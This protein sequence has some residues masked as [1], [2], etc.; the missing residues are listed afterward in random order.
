MTMRELIH[1]L[2]VPLLDD[3]GNAYFRERVWGEEQ[4]GG[5]WHG[6]IEFV[7]PD[8]DS[9]LSTE[10]ETTQGRREALAYWATGLEPEYLEGALQRARYLALT[11]G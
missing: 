4:A 1:E 3:A 11:R 8:G 7:S 2:T 9:V 5:T 10:R 6:W